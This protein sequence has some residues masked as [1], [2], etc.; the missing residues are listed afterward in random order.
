[1]SRLNGVLDISLIAQI[2]MRFELAGF[3]IDSN[4]IY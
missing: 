1:M 2:K 3:V 4:Q